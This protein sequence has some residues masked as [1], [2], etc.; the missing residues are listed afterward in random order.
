M[1]KQLFTHALDIAGAQ[2]PKGYVPVG[3]QE[4]L[5]NLYKNLKT[6]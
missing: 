3:T 2:I 1:S 6:L 4:S 5:N